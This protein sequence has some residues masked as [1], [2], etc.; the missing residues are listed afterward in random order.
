MISQ[1]SQNQT[2]QKQT[3]VSASWTWVLQQLAWIVFQRLLSDQPFPP[4]ELSQRLFTEIMMDPTGLAIPVL[5]HFIH[6]GYARGTRSY[7]QPGQVF[8]QILLPLTFHSICRVSNSLRSSYCNHS[9]CSIRQVHPTHWRW[10]PSSWKYSPSLTY[11]QHFHRPC[12]PSSSRKFHL[13]LSS[14]ASMSPQHSS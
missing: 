1:L 10:I 9:P 14:L 5:R 13:Q 6:R 12:T 3:S 8:L 7:F 2:S 4:A 11:N